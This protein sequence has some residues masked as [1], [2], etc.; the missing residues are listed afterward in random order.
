[1]EAV[2]ERVSEFLSSSEVRDLT[3]STPFRKQAAWL[4]E[5]GVPH[6][7]DGRRVIVSRVHARN[8]LEGRQA[9]ASGGI[10][11]SAVK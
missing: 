8:W 11:W 2:I 3:N 4:V 1:M 10:N 5:H 9:P 6:R 7:V